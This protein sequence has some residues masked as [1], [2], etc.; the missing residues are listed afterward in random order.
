[1]DSTLRWALVAAGLIGAFALGRSTAPPPPAPTPASVAATPTPIPKRTPTA[2]PAVAPPDEPPPA[3]AAEDALRAELAVARATIDSLRLSIEGSPLS[4][5]DGPAEAFR[6]EAY[7]QTLAEALQA[8][9]PPAEFVQMDCD[10][11]PCIA[12]LRVTGPTWR[13][14]LV[15]GC[16]TWSEAYGLKTAQSTGSVDCDGVPQR[17]ALLSPVDEEWLDGLGKDGRENRWRR[18]QHRWEQHQGDLPCPE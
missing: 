1:M 4:W 9:A 10:E 18:L 6:A 15:N 2:A 8:C 14:D 16:P 3:A 7:E 5:D 17:F 11:P 13:N 12:V